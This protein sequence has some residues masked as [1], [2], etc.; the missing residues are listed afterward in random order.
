MKKTFGA[1]FCLFFI[2]FLAFGQEVK[3]LDRNTAARAWA[4]V[5]M[6]LPQDTPTISG[7]GLVVESETN[8]TG[9]KVWLL[10]SQPGTYLFQAVPCGGSEEVKI[11]EI[12][13]ESINYGPFSI[14]IFDGA[15]LSSGLPYLSQFCLVE[16]IHINNSRIEKSS[17]IVNPW[18]RG[19]PK[20]QFSE[21][22]TPDGVYYISTGLL[23]QD[24][25][26]IMG[27]YTI[28]TDIKSSPFGTTVFFPQGWLPPAG[29]ATLTVCSGGR[30]NTNTYE[31]RVY[32]N[33]SGS[34]KG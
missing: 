23:P 11:G 14:A 33:S 17:V 25:V 10:V 34:G 8:G 19:V 21:G 32:V 26:V 1:V 2:T 5:N 22:V 7:G 13:W 9:R 16:A 12:Y 18:D 30:C 3:K 28:A 24:A 27:R 20:N 15:A 31:T 29:P 4:M 6:S